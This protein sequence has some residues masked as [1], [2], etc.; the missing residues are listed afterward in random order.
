ML[1]TAIGCSSLTAPS[2]IRHARCLTRASSKQRLH[3]RRWIAGSSP[4]MT[5]NRQR[6]R[7]MI[8]LPT[9]G[10]A[11]EGEVAAFIRAQDF[12][13]I[14]LGITALRLDLRG[15]CR[16][17]TRL[18]LSLFDYELDAAFLDREP[19][20]VAAAHESERTAGGRIRRDMQ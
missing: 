13:R 1:S 15:L 3:S 20:A 10:R 2:G 7:P 5:A 4:A 18:Q 9:C 17:G 19:D 8:S 14:E 6:R 12:L 16:G 11:Q